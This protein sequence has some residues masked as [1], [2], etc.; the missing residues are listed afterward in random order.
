MELQISY[1][2]P[3][4]DQALNIAKHTAEFADIL[5][6]GSPLILKEGVKSV[7]E[8][9]KNFPD[10]KIFADI[11]MVDRIET[12][13]IFTDC[14][15]KIISV[16]CATSHYVIQ[17]AANIAHDNGAKLALDLLGDYSMGQIAMDAKA[18]NVDI[19][20]LHR[21]HED[22]TVIN[23][24]DEWETIRGNT[25]LP[26]F[27]AGGI[28]RKNIDKVLELKPEGIIIGT[29]IT[30]ANNPAKEAEYFRSLIKK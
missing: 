18:L 7:C 14:G 3:S 1:D 4:L 27:L 26:I 29:S 25:D 16:L 19:L 13:K 23:I 17:K 11:K 2:M 9:K 20:I 5:E 6:V 10:K 21:P 12:I 15:A 28:S 8:F 30:Q 22:G 24:L